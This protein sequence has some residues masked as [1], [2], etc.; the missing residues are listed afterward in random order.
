MFLAA[1]WMQA[2][3]M[4]WQGMLGIFIVVGVIALSVV[5]L[6]RLTGKKKNK[7]KT[8]NTTNETNES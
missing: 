3:T 7:T 1:E 4:M 6:T 5:L 2:L 8:D